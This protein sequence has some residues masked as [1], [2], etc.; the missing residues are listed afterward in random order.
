MQRILVDW[1]CE[2]EVG[3]E[4]VAD[5]IGHQKSHR[6]SVGRNNLRAKSS[7]AGLKGGIRRASREM[8]KCFILILAARTLFQGLVLD[9][10]FAMSLDT[11]RKQVV[12]KFEVLNTMG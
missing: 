3:C 9:R 1:W 8:E 5:A 11:Q 10:C 12:D 7:Q 6:M 2:R 4:S